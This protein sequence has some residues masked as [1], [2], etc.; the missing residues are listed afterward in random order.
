M[1]GGAAARSGL[2]QEGGGRGGVG[3]GG[4]RE[5]LQGLRDH[6]DALRRQNEVFFFL[7]SATC[8]CCCAGAAE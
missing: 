2:E 1:G 6:A 5:D 3:G 7:G 8:P 4:E